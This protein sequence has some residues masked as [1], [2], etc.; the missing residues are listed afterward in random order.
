S[1]FGLNWAG[2]IPLDTAYRWSP[3]N[4]LKDIPKEN[5]MGIEAPLWS[6]TIIEIEDLEYLAFPRIIAYSELGWTKP[7]N[8]NWENF[9]L[10]L[11]EHTEFLKYNN[12]NF[13]RS[14]VIN[15]RE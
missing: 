13:Y 10:R 2:R 11:A 4:Y 12:V 3:E 14:P 5:I 1:E 15:W 6:E 9:K 8:R 7:E